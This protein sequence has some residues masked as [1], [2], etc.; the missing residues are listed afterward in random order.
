MINNSCFMVNNN[1]WWLQHWLGLAHGRRTKYCLTLKIKRYQP[2][3]HKANTKRFNQLAKVTHGPSLLYHHPSLYPLSPRSPVLI[4][5]VA[6]CLTHCHHWR[7]LESA[8]EPPDTPAETPPGKHWTNW[9]S[10]LSWR[11]P[12]IIL[13]EDRS[14]NGSTENCCRDVREQELFR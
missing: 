3:N 12:L 8:R 5:A 1:H 2:Q 10:V 13:I 11:R 6:H 14:Y 7:R 9:W 4:K